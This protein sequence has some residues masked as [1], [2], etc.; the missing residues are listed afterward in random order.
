MNEIDRYAIV[1]PGL[2]NLDLSNDDSPTRG[3]F[4][5]PDPASQRVCTIGGNIANN[6]GG[7]HCL[8]Y[9]VTSNHIL[10]LEVVLPSGELV[11]VG[12]PSAETPGY[13][14]TGAMVGSEGTLGIV[15]KAM[16]RLTRQRRRRSRSCWRRFRRWRPP[17][18]PCRR[19]SPP[20][21]CRRRWR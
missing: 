7:P 3:Y 5:A 4:F 21:S 19:S 13:D 10:G 12:G 2:V 16:V 18:A 15:T 14:L 1:E 17:R 20:E 11:W 9:G 8:K 6:S